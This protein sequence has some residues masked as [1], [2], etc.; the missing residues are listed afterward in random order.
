MFSEFREL[1]ER[2]QL[3]NHQLSL[4]GDRTPCRSS[5]RF[6]K[7]RQSPCPHAAQRSQLLRTQ[8]WKAS[9][10]QSSWQLASFM[11]MIFLFVVHG[12]LVRYPHHRIQ[13]QQKSSI[14]C[15]GTTIPTHH[16]EPFVQKLSDLVQKALTFLNSK[17]F[18]QF[19]L[20]SILFTVLNSQMLT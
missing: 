13:M 4:S 18:R 16:A 3:S 2:E 9:R 6:R 7:L 20:F 10:F 19:S 17:T 11:R 5:C 14:S 8:E 15:S 1:R 12:I